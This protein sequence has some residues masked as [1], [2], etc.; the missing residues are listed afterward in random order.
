[1]EEFLNKDEKKVVDEF[2]YL[3]QS[4]KSYVKQRES[5]SLDSIQRNFQS[6]VGDVYERVTKLNWFKNLHKRIAFEGSLEISRN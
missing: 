3:R 2:N 5:R 6:C 4:V 1:M